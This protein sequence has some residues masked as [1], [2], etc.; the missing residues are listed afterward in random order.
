MLL[1]LCTYIGK[2]SLFCFFFFF[3]YLDWRGLIAEWRWQYTKDDDG[4]EIIKFALK[5]SFYPPF[6]ANEDTIAQKYKTRYSERLLD[7]NDNVAATNISD[8]FCIFDIQRL[9][10]ARWILTKKTVLCSQVFQQDVYWAGSEGMLFHLRAPCSSSKIEEKNVKNVEVLKIEDINDSFQTKYQDS[11]T[12]I[13]VSD[14]KILMGDVNAEIHCLSRTLPLTNE[15]L[16]FTLET[17]N[18]P[19]NYLCMILAIFSGI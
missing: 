11:I 3:A 12:S 17:G 1:I 13:A 4:K 14:D 9:S 6:P 5:R 15:S 18:I 16:R 2:I 19:T 8:M 10:F 7:Y